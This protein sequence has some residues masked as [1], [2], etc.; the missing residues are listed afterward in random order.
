MLGGKTPLY[1]NPRRPKNMNK[2]EYG[3]VLVEYLSPSAY[4]CAGYL[5]FATSSINIR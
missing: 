2:V 1:T 5:S 3:R 4:R